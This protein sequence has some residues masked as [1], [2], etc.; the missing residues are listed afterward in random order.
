M[1]EL[2]QKF[3]QK[4]KVECDVQFSRASEFEFRLFCLNKTLY[5]IVWRVW[6]K[7]K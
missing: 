7:V 5:W 2:D 3:R 6:L 4:Y 1:K